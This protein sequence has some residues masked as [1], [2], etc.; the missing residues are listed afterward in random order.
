[1]KPQSTNLRNY[2][3]AY[4]QCRDH[5]DAWEAIDLFEWRSVVGLLNYKVR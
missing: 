1:M 3:L 2:K 4:E 5:Q